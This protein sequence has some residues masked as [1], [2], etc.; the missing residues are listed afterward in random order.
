VPS[1]VSHY[2]RGHQQHLGA[3]AE[4]QRQ[5]LGRAWGILLKGER[6]YGSQRRQ[7]HHKKMAHKINSPGLIEAHRD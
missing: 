3:D 1:L 7:G 6:R 2:Q 5:K 4:I